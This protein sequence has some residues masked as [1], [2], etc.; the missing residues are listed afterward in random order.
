MTCYRGETLGFTQRW[1]DDDNFIW[2]ETAADKK[3]GGGKTRQC[4][5]GVSCRAQQQHTQWGGSSSGVWGGGGGGETGGRGTLALPGSV[6]AS[7]RRGGGGGGRE[8]PRLLGDESVSGRD[9]GVHARWRGRGFTR[10]WRAPARHPR[11]VHHPDTHAAVGQR[12]TAN[13]IKGERVFVWCRWG[14]R[15]RWKRISFSLRHLNH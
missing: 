10:R 2:E 8:F 12:C 1:W 15:H 3:T 11:S 9:R 5:S 7:G 14:D 4:C 13:Q 6:A